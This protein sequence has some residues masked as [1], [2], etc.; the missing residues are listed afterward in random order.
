MAFLYLK[1]LLKKRT[2]K[3]VWLSKTNVL[4]LYSIR[5]E[6]KLPKENKYLPGIHLYQGPNLKQTLPNCQTGRNERLK[7]M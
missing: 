3:P 5:E 4:A 1:K 7:F 2:L 6:V